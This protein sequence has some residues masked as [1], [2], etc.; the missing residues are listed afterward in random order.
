MI[1]RY[2]A[3]NYREGGWMNYLLRE[4]VGRE[5]GWVTRRQLSISEE[6]RGIG[7]VCKA[8]LLSFE[9]VRD[10]EW[11]EDDR[12]LMKIR[13]SEN[14]IICPTTGMRD[15]VMRKDV[16]WDV[17]DVRYVYATR[18]VGESEADR[19]LGNALVGPAPIGV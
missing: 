12:K 16:R 7:L 10:Q 3:R 9:R 4:G 18:N 15:R 19:I 14:T 6:E 5:D 8:R 17:G 11:G 1:D 13:A 2:N